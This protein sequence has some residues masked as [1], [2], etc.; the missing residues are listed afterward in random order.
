MISAISERIIKSFWIDRVNKIYIL[1]RIKNGLN[2][3]EK[4]SSALFP[5]HL[6]YL[7]YFGILIFLVNLRNL[8]SILDT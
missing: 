6:R 4:R 3:T 2:K 1:S 5:F 8:G 7:L